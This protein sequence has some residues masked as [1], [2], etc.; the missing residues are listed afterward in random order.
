MQ[1]GREPINGRDLLI[2]LIPTIFMIVLAIYMGIQKAQTLNIPD[3]SAEVQQTVYDAFN[4]EVK[5]YATYITYQK[6]AA[7]EG[8]PEAARF[9]GAMAESDNVQSSTLY[10]IILKVDPEYPY[11]ESVDIDEVGTTEENLKKAYDHEFYM[12]REYYPNASYPAAE[13]GISDIYNGMLKC[14]RADTMQV[15]AYDELGDSI[16]TKSISSNNYYVCENC[17]IVTLKSPILRC[18][19][20][21]VFKWKIEKF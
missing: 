9:F 5:E 11:P 19:N 14:F 10:A 6:V 13:E 1:T 17:G 12:S 7:E 21:S 20:C 8:Y 2:K 4:E 16:L 15:A 18:P 3:A